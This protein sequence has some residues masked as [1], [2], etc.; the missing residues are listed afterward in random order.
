[1]EGVWRQTR[2]PDASSSETFIH[3]LSYTHTP[4]YTHISVVQGCE[5]FL[6]PAVWL[7]QNSFHASIVGIL[8]PSWFPI[9]PFS[10]RQGS[11]IKA[12][13]LSV[14]ANAHPPSG[15]K[16]WQIKA[17]VAAQSLVQ[18]TVQHGSLPYLTSLSSASHG[19]VSAHCV[20]LGPSPSPQFC[21]KQQRV[22]GRPDWQRNPLLS[23]LVLEMQTHAE[24]NM[25]LLGFIPTDWI[26]LFDA[27]VVSY[28]KLG[29]G[30][31]FIIIK[32]EKI[33]INKS[34]A[35]KYSNTVHSTS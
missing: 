23:L 21:V 26:L 25:S 13:P 12:G 11:R 20:S 27:V 16:R 6:L 24:L 9:I 19:C 22:N 14:L 33:H 2:C 18:T 35:C 5:L 10:Q 34:N 28:L 4:T 31:L 17:K 15:R 30:F 3:S 1:M 29:H 32:K 8:E 7:F